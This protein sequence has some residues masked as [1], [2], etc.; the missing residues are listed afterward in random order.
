MD[1]VRAADIERATAIILKHFA[2]LLAERDDADNDLIEKLMTEKDILVAAIAGLEKSR[3]AL[4]TYAA[5]L[6]AEC[7]YVRS[8]G[9]VYYSYEQIAECRANSRR[10]TTP[11]TARTTSHCRG[12]RREN[13]P[14]L[15]ASPAAASQDARLWPVLRPGPASGIHADAR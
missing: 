1:R 6:R 13:M 11:P 7:E 10:P 2:L 9:N 4:R 12:C 14:I 5:E 3:D 15:L 8:Q